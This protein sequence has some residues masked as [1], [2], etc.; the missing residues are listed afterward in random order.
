MI[1]EIL[2][3]GFLL[4]H[5]VILPI[6]SFSSA[7]P[8]RNYFPPSPF[9]FNRL[10][11]LS[12][13]FPP[14]DMKLHDGCEPHHVARY[15]VPFHL[16]AVLSLDPPPGGHQ[17]VHLQPGVVRVPPPDLHQIDDYV[18][19]VTGQGI[20][21][22]LDGPQIGPVLDPHLPDRHHVDDD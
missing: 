19:T 18:H 6:A 2:H 22:A 20:S 1:R 21:L 4:S 10:Y 13:N 14:L 17:P 8:C 5:P 7:L 16:Q 9:I 11:N 15:L 12:G 3:K